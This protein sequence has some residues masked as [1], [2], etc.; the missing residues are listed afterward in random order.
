[1]PTPSPQPA[2]P[3]IGTFLNASFPCPVCTQT[4]RRVVSNRGRN[5]QVLTT[6]ICTSCGL[7]HS[8]PMPTREELD[9]FYTSSYRLSYKSSF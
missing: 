6:V 4:E 1:M 8:H 3:A 2:T 5:Q 7:V 9:A